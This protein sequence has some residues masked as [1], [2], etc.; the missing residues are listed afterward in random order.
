[1]IL[2]W[3]DRRGEVEYILCAAI[4]YKDLKVTDLV[5]RNPVNVSEGVV[6]CGHRHPHCMWTMGAVTGKR[7]VTVDVGRYCQGFLTSKNRFVDRCEAA[8]VALG[9]GQ[10]EELVKQLYSEDLY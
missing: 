2:G 5:G 1:M 9:A 7:S 10:I 4:W 3:K 6:F 8:V